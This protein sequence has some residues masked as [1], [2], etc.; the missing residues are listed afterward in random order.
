T[1]FF[2]SDWLHSFFIYPVI[3]VSQGN[4]VRKLHF[5]AVNW[6]QAPRLRR[7]L[8]RQG[9]D[10]LLSFEAQDRAA[11]PPVGYFSEYNVLPDAIAA[12]PDGDLEFS[13]SS[14]SST[15]NFELFFHVSFAIACSLSK[16]QRFEEARR[17]FDYIFDPTDSSS[18]PS[19]VRY[20]RF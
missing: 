7:A 5:Y 11:H 16:N 13:P 18:D 6:L 19:P 3:Q 4:E 8:A 1:P 17:W 10:G 12:A 20:W 2:I 9:V 15:Y 14:A